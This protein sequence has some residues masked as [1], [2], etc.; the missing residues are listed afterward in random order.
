MARTLLRAR[1]EALHELARRGVACRNGARLPSAICPRSAA[2]QP[3]AALAPSAAA[4]HEQRARGLIASAGRVGILNRRDDQLSRL[5]SGQPLRVSR[6]SR[7][8]LR[9]GP[10]PRERATHV[11]RGRCVR[12]H[13]SR[14]GCA[15]RG[16]TARS[17]SPPPQ[18][19]Y[20]GFQP[21]ST[22]PAKSAL[23]CGF[24]SPRICHMCNLLTASTSAVAVAKVELR[25]RVPHLRRA[26]V[27]QNGRCRI[28]QRPCR[29]VAEPSYNVEVS[30]SL[31]LSLSL[32]SLSPLPLSL[33]LSLTNS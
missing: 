31:S 29:Y 7:R 15:C 22:P 18:R 16:W 24:G 14:R 2:P 9:C 21:K 30:L 13:P 8:R 6:A 19:A 23:V 11:S 5:T 33:S 1:S 25:V 26:H 28:A 10:Q 17:R 20:A 27:L 3:A 32:L 4:L 12:R